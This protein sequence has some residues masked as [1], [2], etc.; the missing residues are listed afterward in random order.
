M[1]H[2]LS[3]GFALYFLWILLSGHFSPLL[4]GLGVVSAAVVVFISKRMEVVDH[5]GHPIH[6]S[7]RAML[8]WPW[9]TWEIIKSNIDVARIIVTPKMPIAP[10]MIEL[11]GSQKTELGQAAYANSITL[12]PGT[13]TVGLRRGV[14]SVHALTAEAA[15]GLRK[16]EMDRRVTV[17]E[18]E[19]NPTTSEPAG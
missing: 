13:V 6:M 12:T 16:G 7:W 17:L 1:F 14:F 18:G 3:L 2:T 19:S 8:Y 15:D 5:E 10:N 9:L 4:L 11:K